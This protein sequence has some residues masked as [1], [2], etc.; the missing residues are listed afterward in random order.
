MNAAGI[1]ESRVSQKRKV[2]Q[3]RGG[4]AGGGN[5]DEIEGCVCVSW[6]KRINFCST[7]TATATATARTTRTRI[8]IIV[9][10]VMIK[11]E[12]RRQTQ[13]YLRDCSLLTGS[14]ALSICY[15]CLV[16]V[17][18]FISILE[19]ISQSIKRGGS[20]G[21]MGFIWGF[22]A[23]DKSYREGETN[24]TKVKVRKSRER[25]MER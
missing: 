12:Q 22:T 21:A 24:G 23:N 9:I 4:K 13:R 1:K 7:T 17:F 11:G 25:E 8:I 10:I 2:L 14:S 16:Y 3:C 6:E 18:I 19:L 20:G 5:E 15:V